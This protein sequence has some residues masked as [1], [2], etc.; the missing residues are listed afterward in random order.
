MFTV[1]LRKMDDM[2]LLLHS[3]STIRLWSMILR[4]LS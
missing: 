3:Y 1:K 4:L 2:R